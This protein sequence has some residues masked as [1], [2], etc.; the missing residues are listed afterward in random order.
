MIAAGEFALHWQAHGHSYG[1]LRTIDNDIRAGRT[2]VANVSRTVIGEARRN[3]ENVAVVLITAPPDV[4]ARRI[5]IRA[6]TSD[7]MS[8]DRIGRIVGDDLADFTI[9]NVSN[10]DDH[11]RE[12]L[13]II[14]SNQATDRSAAR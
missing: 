12:L 1:L 9:M 3:Y 13:A 14:R 5:A 6:R 7:A 10:A 4:L 8:S 2:V 11:A